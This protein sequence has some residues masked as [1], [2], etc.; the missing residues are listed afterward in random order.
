MGN[1]RPTFLLHYE[2]HIRKFSIVPVCSSLQSSCGFHADC[3]GAGT[4]PWKMTP[5]L[6]YLRWVCSPRGTLCTPIAADS[7]PICFRALGPSGRTHMTLRRRNKYSGKSLV[8]HAG[9]E[10]PRAASHFSRS[11][12]QGIGVENCSSGTNAARAQC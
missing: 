5:G 3:E 8:P 11:G 1:L 6:Q 7:S 2:V 4:E 10:A 12:P 9:F